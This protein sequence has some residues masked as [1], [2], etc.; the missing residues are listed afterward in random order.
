MGML[1][2]GGSTVYDIESWSLRK[3]TLVH[4]F[5]ALGSFLICCFLLKWFPL[6]WMI[7]VLLVYTLIY[8]LIWL[9]QWLLWKREIK[10]MNQELL[11]QEKE[12]EDTR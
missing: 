3:S 8:F 11:R 2:M 1:A 4:Y 9:T 5:L 7:P 10:R 12:E 6:D